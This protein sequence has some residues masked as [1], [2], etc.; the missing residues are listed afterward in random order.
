M[1]LMRQKCLLSDNNIFCRL[2]YRLSNNIYLIW[3][4]FNSI[5]T[6]LLFSVKLFNTDVPTMDNS[7]GLQDDMRFLVSTTRPRGHACK[8][9]CKSVQLYTTSLFIFVIHYFFCMAWK[10]QCKFFFSGNDTIMRSRSDP[11][12]YGCRFWIWAS[13]SVST[14]E[15]ND[16]LKW[17]D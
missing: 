14:H 9:T 1:V 11:K 15:A 7:L 5:S 6:C 3:I 13:S 12:S 10:C 4:V 17:E 2:G 16:R 8:S